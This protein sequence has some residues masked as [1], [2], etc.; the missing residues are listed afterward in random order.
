MVK[1]LV[2]CCHD[3]FTTHYCGVGTVAR[4]T[5]A[6]A[7]KLIS[8]GL[9]TGWRIDCIAPRVELNS[10]RFDAEY[11]DRVR[12]L[13]CSTGGDLHEVAALPIDQWAD[14]N[15]NWG[16]S[17]WERASREA[18]EIVR[19]RTQDGP[20]IFFAHDIFFGLMCTMLPWTKDCH[21]CFVPHSTGRL[22]NE[23][24][25]FPIEAR[26][27]EAIQKNGHRVGCINRFMKDHLIHDYRV[28]RETCVLMTNALVFPVIAINAAVDITKF[29][30]DHRKKMIFSFGRCDA[31]KGYDRL[32][33]AFCKSGLATKGYQL[34]LLAP[35]DISSVDYQKTLGRLC[36][37]AGGTVIWVKEFLPPGHFLCAKNLAVVVFASMFECAP[38]TP[39]ETLAAAPLVPIIYNHIQPFVEVFRGLSSAR[40]VRGG[41]IDDWV[42]TLAGVSEMSHRKSPPPLVSYEK[43]FW[44]AVQELI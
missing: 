8:Q 3:G 9:L 10:P 26:I 1:T 21:G 19:R 17:Q 5:I 2:I 28:S 14:I 44:S 27:F 33:K 37:Q 11:A 40:M 31:Q 15:T 30:V 12:T 38:L 41:D 34:V 23:D 42:E 22:F 36:D 7:E 16:V 32:V 13:T 20:V 43:N 4:L 39:L 25:R 18:A 35:T 24:Y 29:G 6:A